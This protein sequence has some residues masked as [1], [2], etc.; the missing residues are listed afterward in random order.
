MTVTSVLVPP[1]GLLLLGGTVVIRSGV[2]RIRN[3][4]SSAQKEKES[5][6]EMLR[7]MSPKERNAFLR[8][9][10]M[11]ELK[12]NLE[13]SEARVDAARLRSAAR[14]D[15]LMG[16]SGWDETNLHGDRVYR[17]LLSRQAR[18]ET[19]FR[20]DR[21][22]LQEY[23]LSTSVRETDP[24]QR[25]FSIRCNRLA[26][27]TLTFELPYD[28]GAEVLNEMRIALAR[29]WAVAVGDLSR[30]RVTEHRSNDFQSI[31]IGIP[32]TGIDKDI[33]DSTVFVYDRTKGTV[34]PAGER[35]SPD[36]EKKIFA[37]VDGFREKVKKK[38][39]VNDVFLD[40]EDMK[41]FITLHRLKNSLYQIL[42]IDE[43]DILTVISHGKVT[44]S[45]DA[46]C[47]KEIVGLTRSIHTRRTQ[48]H[49]WKILLLKEPFLCFI[50]TLSVCRIRLRSISIEN[51]CMRHLFTNSTKHHNSKRPSDTT[52]Q[53]ISKTIP[54]IRNSLS[55]RRIEKNTLL[56]KQRGTH[57]CTVYSN[58]RQED[59]KGCIE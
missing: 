17:F 14:K 59:T 36:V 57:N 20:T 29:D 19:A 22:A 37:A 44:M 31:S 28:A 52:T 45:L 26:D 9:E 55:I 38:A 32:R 24:A 56:H 15:V 51:L 1:V 43:S 58:Q 40:Q 49:Q 41:G 6:E 50:L 42:N 54:N 16:R 5:R 2:N 8:R 25:L 21:R 46:L 23:M 7:Q 3:R 12:A 4:K 47:H 35:V 34:Q 10:G 53:S 39:G 13:R 11:K 48:Y 27:G 30:A 18:A 33:A